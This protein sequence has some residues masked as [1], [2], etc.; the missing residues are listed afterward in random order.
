MYTLLHCTINDIV[1]TVIWCTVYRVTFRV[2]N[3]HIMN[4]YY[5]PTDVKVYSLIGI[6]CPSDL[7]R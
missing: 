5:V 4:M 3:T 1:H 6:D 7:V 2:G